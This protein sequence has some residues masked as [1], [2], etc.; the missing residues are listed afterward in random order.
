MTAA[1]PDHRTIG[2]IGTGRMGVVLASR[3]LERGCDVS[4]YNRTRAKAE[5]LTKLGARIVPRAADLADRATVITMVAASDD[6]DAVLT[7]PDGVLSN[8]GDVPS[9]VIDSSTVSMDVSS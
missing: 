4:V 8:G 2:W 7:G 1:A 9:I 3:L 6:L 5:P